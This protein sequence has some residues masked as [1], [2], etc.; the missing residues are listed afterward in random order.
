[1]VKV[2]WGDG[3]NNQRISGACVAGKKMDLGYLL[4][5]IS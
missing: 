3:Y 2:L 5:C 1:M 4:I